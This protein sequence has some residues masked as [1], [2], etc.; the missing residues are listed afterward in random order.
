MYPLYVLSILHMLTYKHI[1]YRGQF[2]L[3]LSVYFLA[4]LF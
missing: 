4:I 1:H 2:T 3:S